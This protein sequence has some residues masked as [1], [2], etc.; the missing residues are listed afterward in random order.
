MTQKTHLQILQ[1]AQWFILLFTILVGIAAFAWSVVQ[2]TKYNAIVAFD[3]AVSNR[4]A[5]D[6]EYQYGAYYDLKGAEVFTQHLMSWFLSPSF[7]EDVYKTADMGY[8][9]KS[10]NSFTGRF[11]TKQYSAQQFVVLFYDYNKETAEKLAGAVAKT[12]E[13][14]SVS[15]IQTDQQTQFIVKAQSPV[16]VAGE[17]N[18]WI[19]L[20][21]GL[22]AGLALSV[23]L[24]YIRE[25][26]QNGK[27][28]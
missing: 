23:I 4:G 7:V 5:A 13:E 17:L 2:P 26:L 18:Q 19:A 21:V 25:Y 6:K 10:V 20:V 11:Q 16:V 27:S 1:H 12:V 8:E 28:A 24:V 14:K 9:I 15:Q 22:I 3:V